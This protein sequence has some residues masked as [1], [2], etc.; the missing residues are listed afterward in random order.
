MGKKDSIASRVLWGSV[1]FADGAAL[2][3]A[4]E[5]AEQWV[6]NGRK[7][8]QTKSVS[9]KTSFGQYVGVT[10]STFVEMAIARPLP[11]EAFY[12]FQHLDATGNKPE[13][14][15]VSMGDGDN[16]RKL[17]ATTPL[18]K[19]FGR[20]LLVKAFRQMG[21]KVSKELVLALFQE[22]AHRTGI[23]S[24]E[25]TK[26]FLAQKAAA[27][28]KA[29]ANKERKRAGETTLESLVL[30]AKVLASLVGAELNTVADVLDYTAVDGMAALQ[31]LDGFGPKATAHLSERL[32]TAGFIT[33]QEA[34]E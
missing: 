16:V 2:V 3:E 21:N 15:F 18:P 31:A 28:E 1:T 4:Q 12:R 27:T 30:D 13:V 5:A 19:G 17:N 22:D 9:F 8:S 20:D 29:E 6:R 32:A 34:E 14:V 10:P 24:E 26:A 25:E 33:V 23:V 11:G 7:P